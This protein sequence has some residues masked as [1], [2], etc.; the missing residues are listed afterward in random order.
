MHVFFFTL[1]LEL[2]KTKIHKILT[3][4]FCFPSFCFTENLK[5]TERSIF[6]W[7]GA[8]GGSL[9]PAIPKMAAPLGILRDCTHPSLNETL[10][11][12]NNV[13]FKLVK[14]GE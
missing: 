12:H 3:I 14:T 9:S 5:N 8:R 1:D 13:T 11:T 4:Q 2:F 6:G 7:R 10:K